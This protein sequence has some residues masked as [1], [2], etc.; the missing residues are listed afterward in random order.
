M[1]RLAALDIVGTDRG[2]IVVADLS[3]RRAVEFA[4]IISQFG[5]ICDALVDADPRAVRRS[6]GIT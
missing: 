5:A 2:T 6:F 1:S 4:I 3:D